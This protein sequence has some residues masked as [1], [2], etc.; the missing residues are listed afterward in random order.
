[1]EPISDIMTLRYVA[2]VADT[3]SFSMA[4]RECHVTQPTVSQQIRKLE[5]HLGYDLFERTSGGVR[6]TPDGERFIFKAREILVKWRHLFAESGEKILPNGDIQL[7]VIPTVGPYI[8]DE[9][10][11]NPPKQLPEI[12]INLVED[13]TSHLVS[14]VKRGQLDAAILSLP[15][16]DSMLVEE[17]LAEDPI[18]VVVRKSE[19]KDSISLDDLAKGTRFFLTEGN[20]F[21]DQVISLC[22]R[23]LSFEPSSLQACS[24]STLLH[25]L[26]W[27][28][29]YMLMPQ[30][31][32]PDL[33]GFRQLRCLPFR[34]G[35]P[36]RHLGLAVRNNSA[37]LEWLPLLKNWLGQ[38][39]ARQIE[40]NVK[41]AKR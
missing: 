10:F 36:Q 13:Y 37:W 25:C 21:R 7:G 17:P 30:L 15:V 40:K 29:G 38:L 31:A 14:L 32:L 8:A 33:R 12:K 41:Y 34:D 35:A 23:Q 19:E 22:G 18:W 26:Q 6:P 4:A 27:Q 5:E 9:L 20:C 39:I 24:F 16:R 28:A 1:M 3:Q 11:R 2:A